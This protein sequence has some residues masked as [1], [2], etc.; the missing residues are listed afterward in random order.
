MGTIFLHYLLL[1]QP[2]GYALVFIGMIFEGDIFVFTSFFIASQGFINFSYIAL[3]IFFGV[4][5]GD[6][7]W[8]WS[9]KYLSRSQSRIGR[10]AD[11][12][13][14]HLTKPFEGHLMNRPFYTIFLSKFV[15][16]VHH[17][18]L[19]RAGSL[20]MKISDYIKLDILAIIL[21]MMIVGSL[22]Y[23]AGTYFNLIRHYVR[24]VEVGLIVGVL[25]FFAVSHFASDYLKKRL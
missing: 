13:F 3:T 10:L 20:G 23:F 21:W 6:L 11:R 17:P 14:G 7:L 15:Y 25:A 18:L 9:G 4:L 22:G 16:G 24:L 8:Y 2:L 12:W 1:W 5:F 19:L